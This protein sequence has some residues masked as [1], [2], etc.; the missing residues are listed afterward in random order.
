MRSKLKF[1]TTG[2][3]VYRQGGIEINLLL[4]YDF[5]WVFIIN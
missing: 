3:G 1:F 5:L 4:I 2:L